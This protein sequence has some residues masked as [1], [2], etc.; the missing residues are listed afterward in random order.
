MSDDLIEFLRARLDEDE[1]VAIAARSTGD[2]P[3]RWHAAYARDDLDPSDWLIAA[4]PLDDVPVAGP[5]LSLGTAAHIA[6]WDPA[7]VL[8]EVGAKR[9]MLDACEA[10][11]ANAEA[12][13]A[14]C[15]STEGNFEA[16]GA[17]RMVELWAQSYADHPDFD[18]EWR[19][20]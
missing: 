20:M 10:L 11:E 12:E 7:R 14:A 6:R 3:G 18:P 9:A 15:H 19:A 1:A 8:A 17:Y 5:R 13:W 2:G 16:V 4:S